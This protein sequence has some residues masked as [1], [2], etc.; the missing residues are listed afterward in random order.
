MVELLLNAGA[1]ANGA[2]C[3]SQ[4]P[5]QLVIYDESIPDRDPIACLLIVHGADVK[6]KLVDH[7]S[8]VA[9]AVICQCGNLADDQSDDRARR[10][11]RGDDNGANLLSIAIESQN[12]E[13]TKMLIDL[14]AD[15]S[16]IDR[17]DV[18]KLKPR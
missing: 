9:S 6:H 16:K 10:Q 3:G 5:L 12:S 14:G 8:A 17:V 11:L 13:A 4:P 7:W 15:L 2:S 18:Q 1:R